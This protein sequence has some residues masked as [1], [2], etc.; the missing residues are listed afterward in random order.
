ML[1]VLKYSSIDTQILSY[2]ISIIICI[3]SFIYLLSI[4]ISICIAY[5]YVLFYYARINFLSWNSPIYPRPTDKGPRNY[6]GSRQPLTWNCQYLLTFDLNMWQF[7]V[8]PPN[9]LWI[10]TRPAFLGFTQ[11]LDSISLNL[12]PN[13]GSF[14]TLFLPVILSALR[15]FSSPFGIQ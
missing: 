15:S 2:S 7:H 5:Y 3:L 14:Q 1:Q 9:R 11:P 12:L 8:I 4:I 13:L 6:H 10:Q